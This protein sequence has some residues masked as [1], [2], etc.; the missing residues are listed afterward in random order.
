MVRWIT[1][2]C[3]PVGPLNRRAFIL[4]IAG[5]AYRAM[6]PVGGKRRCIATFMRGR[7]AARPRSGR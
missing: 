4:I 3:H 5:T 1:N 7:V 6:Q 2:P